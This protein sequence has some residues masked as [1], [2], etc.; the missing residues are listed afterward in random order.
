M[1]DANHEFERAVSIHFA[2]NARHSTDIIVA[3]ATVLEHSHALPQHV[4][5][6][7]PS[8]DADAAA[9]AVAD[10]EQ[11]TGKSGQTERHRPA[12]I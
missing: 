9:V 11:S 12:E 4:Q 10:T 2:P 6:P 1:D 7:R 3:S 5:I 8:A